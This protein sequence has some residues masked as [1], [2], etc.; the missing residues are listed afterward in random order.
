MNCETCNAPVS[1]ASPCRHCGP[2][3]PYRGLE[4]AARLLVILCGLALAVA[5]AARIWGIPL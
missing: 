5:V 1:P 2:V 3:R 4:S